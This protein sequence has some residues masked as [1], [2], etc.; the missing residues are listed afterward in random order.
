MEGRRGHPPPP[1][2]RP[3]AG[4]WDEVPGY[5]QGGG[6]VKGEAKLSVKETVRDRT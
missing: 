5:P 6:R 2:S 1:T 3:G 4:A